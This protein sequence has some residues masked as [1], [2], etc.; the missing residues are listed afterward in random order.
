MTKLTRKCRKEFFCCK[1]K[2][3]NGEKRAKLSRLNRAYVD[4]SYAKIGQVAQFVHHLQSVVG[5]LA[6]LSLLVYRIVY[7]RWFSHREYE[8][9]LGKSYD[10]TCCDISHQ[11]QSFT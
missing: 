10:C 2:E 4:D 7:V 3:W 6:F 8:F 5:K 11:A 1:N 9:E